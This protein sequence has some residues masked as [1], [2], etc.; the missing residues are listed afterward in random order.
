MQSQLSFI[1]VPTQKR[2]KLIPKEAI[3]LGCV[4]KTHFRDLTQGKSVTLENGTVVTPEQVMDKV[5]P[6][7]VF[8][9]NF[10]PDQSYVDFS[11][12]TFKVFTSKYEDYFAENIS[13]DKKVSV[14]YH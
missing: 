5:Q 7:E 4:P 8:I 10:I 2:G 6:S 1:G 11:D 3:K 12:E 9:I 13:D 14:I